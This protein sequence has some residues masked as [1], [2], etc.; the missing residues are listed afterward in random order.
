MGI[1][2]KH[3]FL[4]LDI[5]ELE[6]FITTGLGRHKHKFGILQEFIEP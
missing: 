6:E 3:E 5:D 4:D 1:S 2:Y